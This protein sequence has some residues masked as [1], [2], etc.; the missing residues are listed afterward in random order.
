[1]SDEVEMTPITPE[2]G[3]AEPPKVT[4]SVAAATSAPTVKLKP[5]IR[6]PLIRK[7]VIGGAKPVTLKPATGTPPAP[8]AVPEAAAPAA[9]APK[10]SPTVK[11]VTGPIPAQATIQSLSGCAAI[12]AISLSVSHIIRMLAT[13][14]TR[15]S[16]GVCTPR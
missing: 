10:P 8:A 12:H 6:K 11:S 1:M 5:V 3:G 9:E 2:E 15:T 4:P 14:P 13:A 16:C 7:P